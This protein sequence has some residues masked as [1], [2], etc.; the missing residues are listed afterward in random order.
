MTAPIQ[1]SCLSRLSRAISPL[2]NVLIGIGALCLG[3][4]PSV[5]SV[6]LRCC[7]ESLS[8]TIAEHV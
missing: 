8:L 1:P 6:T 7:V 5:F 3:V 2:G 4:E